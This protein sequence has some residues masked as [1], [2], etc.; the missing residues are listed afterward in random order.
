MLKIVARID[1]DRQILWAEDQRQAVSQLGSPYP[2]SQRNYL[3][4]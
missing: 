2:P 4:R 3:H 1:D